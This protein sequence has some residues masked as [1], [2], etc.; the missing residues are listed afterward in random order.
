M[1][2]EQGV[3]ADVC[4]QE[5]WIEVCVRGAACGQCASPCVSAVFG[6]ERKPLRL[7]VDQPPGL[8]LSPGD[9][10]TLGI[11]EHR[12]MLIAFRVYFLPLLSFFAGAI[13]AS[14]G[15]GQ[16]ESI[17]VDAAVIPGA[18][19]GLMLHFLRLKLSGASVMSLVEPVILR[20]L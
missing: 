19:L 5:C 4:G 11:P 10:V 1:L 18:F 8:V 13:I 12:L 2:E 6:R 20:R 16:M 15:A 9:H 7:K 17:S 3:V 14:M